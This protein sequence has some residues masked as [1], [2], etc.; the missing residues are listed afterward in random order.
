MGK[1]R[2]N[3]ENEIKR[4]HL[5]LQDMKLV[6]ALAGNEKKIR[7]RAL[8]NLKEWFRQRSL[9]MPFTEDDYLRIW[10][11]LFSTMWMSDKP[12][13]QEECA[14]SI[15][16]LIHFVNEDSSLLF[17]KCGLKLMT[18]EWFGIDQWRLDK[19]LMLVRRMLRQGFSFLHK[20][21]WELKS[22]NEFNEI[23]SKTVLSRNE[24]HVGLTMHFLEIYLEELA[25]VSNGEI[26][27]EQ[28]GI[29]I[30]PFIN[31]IS[32]LTDDRMIKHTIESIF[33]YLLNQSDV[34]LEYEARFTAWKKQ[35]FPG[36]NINAIEKIEIDNETNGNADSDD[37]VDETEA[38]DP[39]AGN[40]HVNLPQLKF[41]PQILLQWFHEYRFKKE[42]TT[43]G[44]KA[45][46]QLNS[47]FES[48]SRGSYPLGFTKI[49]RVKYDKSISINKSVDRLEEFQEE[50]R[51]GKKELF[52]KPSTE[53]LDKFIQESE[54]HLHITDIV[55]K[56]RK[57][58]D[59]DPNWSYQESFRR[60][61][62]LWTV[63]LFNSPI[64]NGV[65]SNKDFQTTPSPKG[66][67]IKTRLTPKDEWSE[68]LKEGETEIFI[69]SNKLKK[70][71]RNVV[72]PPNMVKNPFATSTPMLP[73]KNEK[74]VRIS[75]KLNQTQE[76]HEHVA[77]LK[78][79]P[80]IPYDAN[81]KPDKP[82]LKQNCL[83]SPVNPFYRKKFRV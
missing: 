82:L 2:R 17:F 7:D 31:F 14:E 50:M 32:V 1:P 46:C 28:V 62:G 66:S 55:G 4:K 35:G 25:K 21:N 41:D 56:K 60:N 49:K 13:I 9:R 3:T 54:G 68:P 63:H 30:E 57:S 79:S 75:L 51:R 72:Q 15:A 44:K 64:S 83:K 23:L 37:D 65:E 38:L 76:I 16:N 80:G 81:K 34:G 5:V 78:S 52:R 8:R 47:K 26:T 77:Q 33:I 71:I 11:G 10:K 22:I 40:V 27:E 29:F 70:K 12:L 73:I 45:L 69:P 6:R 61:S 19:F 53:N 39:R 59:R 24:K 43:K 58:L 18:I 67:T 42:T 20:Q 74:K 36:R 48:L